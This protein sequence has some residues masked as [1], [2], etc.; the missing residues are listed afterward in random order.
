VGGGTEGR[1]AERE[2]EGYGVMG[3][4]EEEEEEECSLLAE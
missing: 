1:R 3:Q 2:R 4:E